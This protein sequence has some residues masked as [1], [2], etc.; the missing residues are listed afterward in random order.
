MFHPVSNAALC[1]TRMRWKKP[2]G[3]FSSARRMELCRRGQMSHL[4][5]EHG[6]R[7]P[8]ESKSRAILRRWRFRAEAS[9]DEA[10]FFIGDFGWEGF[11]EGFETVHPQLLTGGGDLVVAFGG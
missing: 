2:E 1:L 9:Y 10:D 4:S 11:L 3:S 7:F 8:K 6:L 5:R